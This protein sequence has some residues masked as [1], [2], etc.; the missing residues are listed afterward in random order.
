MHTPLPAACRSPATWA[1]CHLTSALA[2]RVER[3]HAQVLDFL[4][5][6]D[7]D[8]QALEFLAQVLGLFGQ[9]NRV[10]NVRWQVAQVAG[11]RHAAGNGLCV[12]DCA[13]H[14]SLCGLDGQ[15]GDFLIGSSD[16][17]IAV[18]DD[19]PVLYNNTVRFPVTLVAKRVDSSTTAI[20]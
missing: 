13:L 9:E 15:Q 17:Y 7:L 18:V 1:T 16:Q 10:A 12:G 11:E 4:L 19:E 20:Y 3:A 5:V 2:D 14:F 8:F 6:K